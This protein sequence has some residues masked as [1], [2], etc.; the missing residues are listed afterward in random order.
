MALIF[1][2]SHRRHTARMLPHEHTSYAALFFVL[3]LVGVGLIIYSSGTLAGSSTGSVSVTAIVPGPPIT[4]PAV[5]TNPVNGQHF[6]KITIPVEGTCPAGTVVKIFKN[7]VLAGTTFCQSTNLFSLQIDLFP[8]KNE[9]VA[10]DY[11]AFGHVGPDSGSIFVYYDVP[12]GAIAGGV[13]N[14]FFIKT[15]VGIYR[16][17]IAGQ[18]LTWPFEIVGGTGPYAISINWGDGKV[19]LLSQAEKGAFKAEHIYALGGNYTV[20][21]QGTDEDSNSA[22]LQVVAVVGGAVGNVTATTKPTLFERGSLAVLWPL[23]ALALFMVSSFWLG[24]RY[25]KE[26]LEKLGYRPTGKP[27]S[28]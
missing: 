15:D 23:Y 13:T 4:Q 18:A 28:A 25:E 5:I 2:F 6:T 1:K 7:N 26:H 24:D 11:D 22:Y 19:S 3:M 12:A 16:G 27:K 14:Q 20:T 17:I 9:L 21:V 8:G 10:H